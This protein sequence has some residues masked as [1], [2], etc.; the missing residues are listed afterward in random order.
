MPFSI[1]QLL[2]AATFIDSVSTTAESSPIPPLST[3]ASATTSPHVSPISASP[4]PS[5]STL[6]PQL[7]AANRKRH[8]EEL[9]SIDDNCRSSTRD[10]KIA[11]SLSSAGKMAVSRDVGVSMPSLQLRVVQQPERARVSGI[12]ASDRRPLHPP[13]IIKLEGSTAEQ[14]ANLVLFVSLWSANMQH[15]MT[16]STKCNSEA[17]FAYTPIQDSANQSTPDGEPIAKRPKYNLAPTAAFTRS[18]VLLGQLVS[19]SEPLVDLDDRQGLFF[20][21]PELAIRSS[22]A[23]RLKFDLFDMNTMPFGQPPIATTTT[24]VFRVYNPK[25]FPGI[26]ETTALSRCFARQ[27][28]KI[29]LRQPVEDSA[30]ASSED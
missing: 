13:P 6:F 15:E 2:D 17:R 11:V 20:M 16:F 19:I 28:M 8:A 30:A 27:G 23:F 9:V 29:R 24:N 18:Q 22:G 14:S 3:A 26:T 25:E 10:A 1:S 21:H 5:F 12:S 7:H 4:L